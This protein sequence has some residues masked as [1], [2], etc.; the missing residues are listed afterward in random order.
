MPKKIHSAFS[1]SALLTSIA[2][3]LASVVFIF[4]IFPHF[5]ENPTVIGCL[6]GLA[7]YIILRFGAEKIVVYEESVDQFTNNLLSIFVRSKKSSIPLIDIEKAYIEVATKS[8]AAEIGLAVVLHCLMPT[9]KTKNYERPIY[10]L[11]KNG[12][13]VEYS[14]EL[15]EESRQKI[16]DIVNVL[17]KK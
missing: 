15:N 7:I 1:F 4:Y 9:S 11:L 16:V 12:D 8:T 14:T 17:L 5:D 3:R 2:F 13:I 6:I 10:F